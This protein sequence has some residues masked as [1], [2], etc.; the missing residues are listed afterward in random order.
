MSQLFNYIMKDKCPTAARIPWSN[1]RVQSRDTWQWFRC[2]AAWHRTTTSYV[3]RYAHRA[4]RLLSP[5]TRPPELMHSNIGIC[6]SPTHLTFSHHFLRLTR[7]SQVIPWWRGDTWF[8]IQHRNI[9]ILSLPAVESS[10]ITNHWS[11]PNI[12]HAF[13]IALTLDIYF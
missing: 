12:Y 8:S 4:P 1:S 11:L 7:H 3:T 13:I 9:M 2:D 10:T 6:Q 5:V